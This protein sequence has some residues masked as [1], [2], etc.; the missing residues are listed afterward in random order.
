MSDIAKS[1][2][3]KKT[4]ERLNGRNLKKDE[5]KEFMK[6]F[7]V[8]VKG[9]VINGKPFAT[10]ANLKTIGTNPDL[11]IEEIQKVLEVHDKSKVDFLRQLYIRGGHSITNRLFPDEVIVNLPTISFEENGNAINLN[12]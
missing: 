5:V 3:L 9:I 10:S 4:E 2:Q 8:V 7:A 6:E 11:S 1:E 12:Y